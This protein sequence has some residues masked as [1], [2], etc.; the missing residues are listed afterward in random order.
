M[1]ACSDAEGP[2]LRPA[3]VHNATGRSHYLSAMEFR[4]G[5]ALPA[6]S[7]HRLWNPEAV[8]PNSNNELLKLRVVVLFRAFAI[9]MFQA[10]QLS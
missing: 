5:M 10:Y 9:S 3:T 6:K 1:S 4:A 8:V 2:L 7:G